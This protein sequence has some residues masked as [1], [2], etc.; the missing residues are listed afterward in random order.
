MNRINTLALTLVG[1]LSLLFVSC[2]KAPFVTMTGPRSYTFTREGGIQTFAFS[3][4]R[5]WSVSSSETWIRITPSSG[6]ASDGD[7]TVT[8]TC[9][10]NTTYDPRIAT[11]TLKVEELTEIISV[12]QDTG[13]GLILSPTTFDLTNAAQT[14]EVEVRQNVNYAIEIDEACTD[15]IKK[16][17]TKALSTDKV[18]FTIAANTSYDNRE[19]K[20]TFKQTDGDLVQTVTVRQSQTNG[21]F[22]TTPDYNLS[23]EAHT[24]SVEVKAN[25]EF[26]V[27]SQ[28]E[29]IKFVE[30]KA[31]TPST[32]TLSVEA[33]ESY[34]NRTGTVL[35]KQKN[36]DLTGTITV[37]QKQTDYM[38]V[39]PTSFEVTNAEQTIDVVVT[40]NVSYSVVIPDDAKSWISIVSN[41]QT[42]ALTDDKV[43]LAIAQNLTYDP[44]T[45]S[46]TIKQTD[47]PLA[48]TVE[49]KQA[50]GDGLFVTTPEY[51]LSNEAH[52]VSVELKAN[53]EFEVTPEVDWITYVDTK[54]LS[55]F[56]VTLSVAANEGYDNRTGK[57]KIKQKNGSL[58]ETVT[59]NQ[60]Q[61]DYLCVT[62][63]SFELTNAQQMVD[64][65][66][67]DNVS[68]DVVIPDEAKS[69][70]SIS[71]NTQTKALVDDQV[72]L[73][74]AKNT[75]YDD[76]ET[77]ITI[78]Q[79]DGSLAAT[80]MIKQACADGLIVEKTS[81]DIGQ[82]GGSID[83]SVETNIE[84]E[85][86]P[87]VDW[88][89][90]VET[91]ALVSSTIILNVD[92]NGSILARE[93]IV[94]IV[95]KNGSLKQTVTI[96]QSG[97]IAVNAITLNKTE[98]RLI[99]GESEGL[100]ATVGPDSA[101]DKTVTWKSSEESVATVD[102]DGV[103]KAVSKGTT[104]IKATA[105]DG[106]GVYAEC[107]VK[108]LSPCPTGAV[109]LGLSVYWATCNL[110]ESGFVSSPEDCGDYYAWGETEP[111]YTSESI[112]SWKAGSEAGYSW[113][114]YKWC[115]G[116]NDSFSK[117]NSSSSR[118]TVDNKTILD[119]EDD[120]AH[121]KLGG[122][123]RMPTD[124]EC[125]ELL[126]NCSW[127]WVA[128]YNN[129]GM[130]G[131]LV[132]GPNGNSIFLPAAGYRQGAYLHHVG[133]CGTYWSSSLY[134][135]EPTLARR[136]YLDSDYTRV[137]IDIR[138][139]GF[140]VRPVAE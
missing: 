49:I 126:T 119:P 137:D 84:Y 92:K 25:V 71:S 5:D 88:I 99:V 85:V 132:T 102:S 129:T 136:I 8:I 50:Q 98:L 27:T 39:T 77:S 17:G 36:G 35:V 80:I 104:T 1:A 114:T 125:S 130:S 131:R 116:S 59:I 14:I 64:I 72:V 139:Y 55:A 112:Y 9:S 60:K 120:V 94:E 106:S 20:I 63:T 3:C 78:K 75:S 29:W 19:G 54:A 113:A 96:K 47:G 93:G 81:Y 97:Q 33:N 12:S 68:Y 62:P 48:E 118:G 58:E 15:W 121:V 65:E 127:K 7:I 79:V 109:D 38:S 73:S 89:H 70:I 41:T 140:A 90:Q 122:S 66:V 105:N 74:I 117:Y 128:N 111:Y 134:A 67:K 28:A 6:A 91:K 4:N 45:A 76:R 43:I 135:D 123:W 2:E 44:R 101:A 37:N 11:I 46:I 56:T 52:T 100:V 115:N 31:L 138:C 110:C 22:I 82:E 53:V 16:G 26:E 13:L 30:T 83:V 86:T 32:V 42:K 133:Y 108:V 87:K 34:D 23:N 40:D 69:W 61:T 24:L 57:V 18:T 21:L 124:K 10:P 103:V 51:N 107:S 95:Q